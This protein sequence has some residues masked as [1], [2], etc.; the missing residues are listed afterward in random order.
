M[1][2]E[3]IGRGADTMLLDIYRRGIR[4]EEQN[5]RIIAEQARASAS[6]GEIHT[7][8]TEL[9]V[10]LAKITAHVTRIVPIVDAAEVRRIELAGIWK[11]TALGGRHLGKVG[12]AAVVAAGLWLA[13]ALQ[14]HLPEWL[15]KLVRWP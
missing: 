2:G 12:W 11:L 4:M 5:K 6:R 3:P 14:E 15:L 1:N 10:D 13:H 9:T 8:L 7:R